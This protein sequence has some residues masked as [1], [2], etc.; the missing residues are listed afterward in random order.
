MKT[1]RAGDV[2][3]QLK[4]KT[5]ERLDRNNF[6]TGMNHQ[7]YRDIDTCATTQLFTPEGKGLPANQ[8]KVD[9]VN[10]AVRSQYPKPEELRNHLSML[11]DQKPGVLVVLSSDNDIAGRSLPAYFRQDGHYGDVSVKCKINPKAHIATA[12]SLELRN[13]RIEITANGKTTPLSVM[14]VTNWEDR[15]TIEPPTLKKLVSDINQK[16]EQKVGQDPNYSPQPFIHCSAGIGRTGVVAGAIEILKPGNKNTP[17]EIVLQLRETGS[18][19]MVQTSE[20]YNTLISLHKE[21][22]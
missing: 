9:G 1:E 17:E 3:G 18:S 19:N 12:G 13:Y 21:Y 11:A 7:R 8:M 20:Q 10:L 14:H 16:I 6:I 5:A 15:T 22:H 4:A 2:F